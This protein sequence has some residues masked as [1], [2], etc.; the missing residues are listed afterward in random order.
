MWKGTN[1]SD[2]EIELQNYVYDSQTPL[3]FNPHPPAPFKGNKKFCSVVL[4]NQM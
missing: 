3:L 4:Q 2:A 1:N